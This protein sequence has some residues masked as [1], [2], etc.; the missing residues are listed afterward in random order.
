MDF[1]EIT[2][3]VLAGFIVVGSLVIFVE[4]VH[5]LLRDSD[6]SGWVKVAWLLALLAL[7]LLTCIAYVVV[8]GGLESGRYDDELRK[9]EL[10]A[11]RLKSVP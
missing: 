6:R 3:L 11:L 8:R 2:W 5:D 9:A 1:W 4:I 7:P 10:E